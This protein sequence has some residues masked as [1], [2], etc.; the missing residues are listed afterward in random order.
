LETRC[1][2]L[3]V[4]T[5]VNTRRGLNAGPGHRCR[6]PWV[7]E[8]F[9]H[10]LLLVGCFFFKFYFIGW[11]YFFFSFGFLFR[12]YFFLDVNLPLLR[13]PLLQPSSL[14]LGCT[15]Y[16][17][18]KKKKK[19]RENYKTKTENKNKRESYFPSWWDMQNSVGV[20]IYKYIYNIYKYI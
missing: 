13:L 3:D 4:L 14:H 10:G 15:V 16:T 9:T 12:F 19:K 2:V 17:E 6:T 20:C 8:H 18:K 1:D 11:I 7:K 5:H